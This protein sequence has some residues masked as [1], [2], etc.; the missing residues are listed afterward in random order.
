[1]EAGRGQRVSTPADLPKGVAAAV[2]V[3]PE[4]TRLQAYTHLLVAAAR[5]AE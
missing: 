3:A 2:A 1:M 4:A 5:C